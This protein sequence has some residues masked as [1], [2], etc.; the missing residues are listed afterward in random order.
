MR[1]LSGLQS[2][3]LSNRVVSEDFW[4]V[5]WGF[6]GIQSLAPRQRKAGDSGLWTIR[7]GRTVQSGQGM[8]PSVAPT[9]PAHTSQSS[10]A[11]TGDTWI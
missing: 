7:R 4:E 9:D 11:G 10:R 1:P 2:A 8:D 6:E 3:A 5:Q